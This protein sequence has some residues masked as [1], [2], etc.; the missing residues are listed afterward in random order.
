MITRLRYGKTNTFFVNGLLI[1]TDYAGTLPGFYQEIKR[2]HIL[3]SDI[4]YILATH[5][6][7]DHI[8]LI[9]ELTDM[10]ITL[11]LLRHQIR[12]VHYSDPI[13]SRTPHLPYKPIDESKAT[14]ISC[15][16]SRGYLNRIG[17]QG[18]IIATASHSQDGAAVLFDDGNCCVGDVE[19]IEWIDAYEKN[20]KL[21]D[22]WKRI[23]SYHPTT[24]RYSHI[25]AQPFK[26]NP[27]LSNIT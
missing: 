13:F 18:E 11:L 16:E 4:R 2:N 15:Q 24:I 19:P 8:G 9:G 21:K 25:P 27:F 12:H 14:I 5:Y 23:A 22:D 1:D 17:I 26:E 20:Q 6:H 7:P 10:G 3:L